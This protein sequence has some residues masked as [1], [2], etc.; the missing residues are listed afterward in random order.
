MR[1]R[2]CDLSRLVP[3]LA[4]VT[5]MA[6]CTSQTK[7]I[8]VDDTTD[9]WGSGPTSQ[10]FRSMGQLMARSL[11]MLPQ[12]QHATSP[13]KIAFVG[14]TNNSNEYIDGDLVLKQMRTHLIKNANGRIVFLD[15]DVLQQIEH[16]NRAKARGKLTTSSEHTPYGA[17]FY[18]TGDIDSVDRPTSKGHTSYMRFSFRLTDAGTSAILWE[19]D[20]EMKKNVALG[21][22]YK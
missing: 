2:C 6:G 17:D 16:E 8:H 20:Y 14:V 13:P 22:M 19:D 18:L 1:I 9:E 4:V 3:C 15:R 7:R 21:I 11:I 12:I 5:V 10:D